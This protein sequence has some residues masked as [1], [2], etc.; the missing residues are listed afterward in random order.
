M[1]KNWLAAGA[2]ALTVGMTSTIAQA[3]TTAR[4]VER[5]TWKEPEG[6]LMAFYSAVLAFTPVRAAS[7]PSAG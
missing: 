7:S 6:R 4:Y 1:M 3:Q 5:H 2:V